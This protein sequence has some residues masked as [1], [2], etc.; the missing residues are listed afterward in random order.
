MAPRHCLAALLALS[1]ATAPRTFRDKPVLWT[2]DDRRPFAP[3]PRY[4]GSPLAWTG[5]DETLFRPTT[6]ALQLKHGGE[7]RNVNALDE[8]PDSSWFENRLSRRELSTEEMVR[9]SCNAPPPDT[10]FP[11]TVVGAKLEGQTPGFRIRTAAGRVY[12][13]EFDFPRQPELASIAGVFGSRVYW[14]AGFNAVCDRVAFFREADMTVPPLERQSGKNR[15]SAE[16]VHE[17]LTHAPP[18]LAGRFRVKASLLA[19]GEPLGNWSWRDTSDDDPNDIIP[20]EDRRELRATRLLTA[21]LNHYDTGDNQT[22]SMWIPTGGGR[23][24]VKHHAIDWNDSLGFL[25]APDLDQI[26]RR[27]GYAYYLDVGIIGRDFIN[28]GLKQEPWDRAHFGKA[29]ETLGYFDD[30]DFVPEEWK[31]GYP[32]PAFSRMTERDAAWMARILARFTDE[33]IDALL[34]EAGPTLPSST[35]SSCASCVDGGTGSSGAGWSGYRPS[36]IRC[37]RPAAPPDGSACRIGPRKPDWALR[38]IRRPR[39]GATANRRCPPRWIASRD[40]SVPTSRTTGPTTSRST[41]TAAVPARD[42][43]GC[44]LFGPHRRPGAAREAVSG[45]RLARS[46]AMNSV[47]FLLVVLMT[48]TA[49]GFAAHGSTTGP[50]AA[51]DARTFPDDAPTVS[52]AHATTS[53]PDAAPTVSAAFGVTSLPD[54]VP[55][56]TSKPDITR[57]PENGSPPAAADVAP[58]P[59]RN[60]SIGVWDAVA[61]GAL[62]AGVVTVQFGVSSPSQAKWASTGFDDWVRGWLRIKSEGAEGRPRRRATCCSTPSPQLRFSTRSSS[63]VWSTSAWTWRGSLRRW[64]PRP[65]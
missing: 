24:W 38:P 12:F 2:D 4:Y 23:G 8:V 26:S 51:P 64:T 9:G 52:D 16:Q 43:R 58:W 46:P 48:G 13:L 53:L 14:A 28:L 56:P 19:E 32:N 35:R 6:D 10:E 1:C 18:P 61:S 5:A 41:S 63:P 59:K 11:W 3:R 30:A 15:I 39:R 27:L 17:I 29:G 49:A 7:S 57:V 25:W 54:D 50:D 60:F 36:P 62:V 22:L 34:T 33:R 31:S 21:W 55:T 37:W 45:A 47:T 40:A 65:F 44:T 42:P 20:H